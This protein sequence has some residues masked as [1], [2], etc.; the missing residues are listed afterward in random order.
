MNISEFV[1]N[2][3][4]LG[5]FMYFWNEANKDKN[6]S[7]Y[8]LVR[9]RAPSNPSISSIAAVGFGLTAIPIG[10]KKGWI[11]LKEGI[12][13]VN[14][15]LDTL[16][17]HAENINGFFYHFLD[18]ET[19]K[20][21]W[22]CEVSLIDTAIAIC[23][24]LFAGEYFGGEIRHKAQ[25]L[26]MN[27]NWQWYYDEDKNWFYMGY[28]PERGFEGHWDFYA[29][30]LMVYFL[31]SASPTYP[32]KADAF[33]SF[34]RNIATYKNYRFINSWL[35]SIF[36][37]QFSH[38]WFDLR[39][40]KDKKGVDWFENSIQATLANREYCI[41]NRERFKGFSENSWGLTACDGPSGYEGRYGSLPSGL[42]NNE[43]IT[44]GTIP[45]AGAAGS[46]V[47]TPK[48]STEALVY[49]YKNIPGLFGKYGFKDAFNIDVEP[50]WI[51]ED[52]LGID[53]GITLLM[54]ENYK[55]GF[56]WDT[57]MKNEYVNKAFELIGL[58]KNYNIFDKRKQII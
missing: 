55:S 1:L 39:N 27:V 6:S 50:L 14:G 21:V 26:Y 16:L 40:L 48:E 41:D 44:D 51:A 12:E 57:F 43:N 36:T 46:I 58:D 25:K 13:R 32:V 38:A 34:F 18:L 2:Q 17:Y 24:A 23:G 33:Y 35:G 30:Q 11:S 47:F 8:G 4:A 53:K 37:Y 52:Y 7:G 42:F 3:E 20:R 29:E 49:Y 15:T 31:A 5:S 45:P 54:I 56:V 10:I 19:A 28:T 22:N 9:D